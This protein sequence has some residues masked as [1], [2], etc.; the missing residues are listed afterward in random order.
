MPPPGTSRISQEIASRS[1]Q[2]VDMYFNYDE[3]DDDGTSGA[4]G[5]GADQYPAWRGESGQFKF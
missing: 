5:G 1:A 4:E 3:E 2:L